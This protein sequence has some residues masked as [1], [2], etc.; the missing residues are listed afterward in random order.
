MLLVSDISVGDDEKNALAKVIDSQWLTTGS[1]VRAF[2]QAFAAVHN[3]DDAVA[4]S[5]CTAG[6]HLALAAMEIGPGDEVLVPSLSFVATANA[7]VYAGAT[8]V[9]VDVQSLNAPLICLADAAAKLTPKTRAV[10]VMHYAGHLMDG[11]AW[12]E[13]ARQHGL[14]LIEDFS[15]RRRRRPPADIR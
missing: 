2:E 15:A 10:I 13:F 6:L 4:V 5:S 8:P 7:V 14:V 9:F 1:R 3:V 12:C 11:A